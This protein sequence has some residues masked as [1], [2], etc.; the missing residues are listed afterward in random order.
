LVMHSQVISTVVN[1]ERLSNFRK[2]SRLLA[3]KQIAATWSSQVSELKLI[4]VKL[5]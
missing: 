3:F 4:D 5:F 1:P 2:Y